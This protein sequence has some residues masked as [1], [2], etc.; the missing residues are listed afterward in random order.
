MDLSVVE[1]ITRAERGLPV[2]TWCR[3]DGIDW[4]TRARALMLVEPSHHLISRYGTHSIGEPPC[5]YAAEVADRNLDLDAPAEVTGN[6]CPLI[7]ALGLQGSDLPAAIQCLFMEISDGAVNGLLVPHV[8]QNGTAG[9]QLRT[10][11]RR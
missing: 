11:T 5:L 10:A 8:F 2:G 1:R 4:R 9:T 6:E 7:A 3:R